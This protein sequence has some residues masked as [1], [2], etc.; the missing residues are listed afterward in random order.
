MQAT[1]SAVAADFRAILG[2]L[3]LQTVHFGAVSYRTIEVEAQ[4]SVARATY[5]V[6]EVEVSASPPNPFMKVDFGKE[7]MMSKRRLMLNENHIEVVD[8]DTVLVDGSVDASNITLRV[9]NLRGGKLEKFSSNTWTEITSSPL[10]FTLEELRNGLVSFLADSGVSALTFDIQAVDPQGNL[11]DSD[12]SDDDADPVSV[13]VPV[14]PLKEI[15]AGKKMPVN[16][17]H[18][19]TPDDTT[20]GAWI[21]ADNTPLTIFVELKHGK[22]WSGAHGAQKLVQEQ[23]FS[24]THSI[25]DSKIAI[26][27]DAN[28]W[29]LVLEG[30]STAAVGDF[31]AVLDAL[32]LQT[33][34]FATAS[35]RTISVRPD[36][37]V[38]VDKQDYY[39]RDVLVRASGSMPYV[40]VQEFSTLRFGD[41]DRAILLSSEFFVEDFDSSA[42]DITIVMTE[43]LAGATLQKRDNAGS[44]SDIIAPLEFTLAELQQGLIAI[45]M[46][47]AL[48]EKITFELKAKDEAEQL[49]R[50]RHG[51]CVRRRCAG[52]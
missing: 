11:S 22:R 21:A 18:A 29:R 17:D 5:Y 6:R 20:L 3:E 7:R 28:N 46:P 9:T 26:S 40:G 13:S 25:A 35:E 33:V 34:R 52:V 49:E 48:G 1:A 42:A 43:L 31:K 38:E 36:L 41:D 23:L 27:W 51:Q 14:I 30:S 10:E 12:E 50:C 44:Y 19:L 32:E 4:G 16:D 24:K 47:G 37:Q 2:A 8:P 45:Y 39:T 15:D